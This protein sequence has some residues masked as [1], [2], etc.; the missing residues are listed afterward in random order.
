MQIHTIPLVSNVILLEVRVRHDR[1]DALTT[2][3]QSGG[4]QLESARVRK[5]LTQP[6]HT[7]ET[8]VVRRSSLGV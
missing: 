6:T 7:L 1:E 4:K 5:P 8:V 3:A 2:R